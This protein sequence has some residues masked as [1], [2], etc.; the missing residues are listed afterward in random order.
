[1][2]LGIP[3]VPLP[4][5]DIRM[6]VWPARVRDFA[7][8][9]KATN[10]RSTRWQQPGFDQGQDQPVVNVTWEEAAAFCKWLTQVEQ[11]SGALG[12]S[13][14]Y[15]LP[16]DLEWSLAVG[17]GPEQGETPE[18]RDL[19]VTGVY[20]WG[21]QWPPPVGAGNYAGQELESETA[22]KNYDDGFAWTSPV[23]SFPPNQFGLYDMGG[24]VWQWVEDWWNKEKKDKVARGAS[25]YNGS[26]RLS[27]LSSCRVH[28]PPNDSRDNYGFRIV[29]VEK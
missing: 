6:G 28:T 7:A 25:W 17:L 14:H 21:T 15:R 1:N 18:Q 22:I 8:F 4:G 26:V 16:T 3:L 20:P 10:L 23:G 2:S 19:G 24:N 9:A 29:L 11:E 27:L 13:L 5:S 12:E